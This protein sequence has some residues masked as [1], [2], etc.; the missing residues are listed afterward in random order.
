MLSGLILGDSLPLVDCPP[1][2]ISNFVDSM[3]TVELLY[4][5][6]RNSSTACGKW[7]DLL[8]RIPV[9]EK[10]PPRSPGPD[11]PPPPDSRYFNLKIRKFM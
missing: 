5:R 9:A 3:G 11:L 1:P 6:E 7:V 10:H 4:G 8:T 2:Y